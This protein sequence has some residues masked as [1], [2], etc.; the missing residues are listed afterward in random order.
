MKKKKKEE[1][2]EE[3]EEGGGEG[4][5]REEEEEEIKNWG[6]PSGSSAPEAINIGNPM[7]Q[8]KH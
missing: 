6:A 3:E 4:E 7:E 1:K 5:E 2:E 8:A